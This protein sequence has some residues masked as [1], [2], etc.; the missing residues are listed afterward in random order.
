MLGFVVGLYADTLPDDLAALD[1]HAADRPEAV[2][3]ADRYF[4]EIKPKRVGA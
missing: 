3:R 1:G 4:R 2:A